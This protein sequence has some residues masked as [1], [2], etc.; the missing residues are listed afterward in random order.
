[1]NE[2]QSKSN[3]F[4]R[5]SKQVCTTLVSIIVPI[6]ETV[7]TIGAG[8]AGAMVISTPTRSGVISLA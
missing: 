4:A 3:K 5:A 1:M 8:A 7:W 6:F 2:K